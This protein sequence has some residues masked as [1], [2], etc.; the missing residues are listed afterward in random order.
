MAERDD[1][2]TRPKLRHLP[3]GPVLKGFLINEVTLERLFFQFNPLEIRDSRS[4]SF[5]KV[6]VPGLSHPFLQFTAGDGRTLSFRLEFSAVGYNR[7]I[8]ADI[9]WLQ[10]LQYPQWGEGVIKSA[11]PRVAF[12]FGK[13]LRLRGVVTSTEVTYKRWDPSL[14]R[15]LEA[16]VTIDFEEYVPKSVNMWKVRRGDVDPAIADLIRRARPR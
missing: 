15:L 9:K 13:L 8:M 2:R 5:E 4:V 10:S 3:F 12:V 6:Q 7:D 1:Y 11:P 14:T 16:S